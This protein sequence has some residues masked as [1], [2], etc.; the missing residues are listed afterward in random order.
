LSFPLWALIISIVIFKFWFWGRFII[1]FEAQFINWKVRSKR[2]AGA[3][4]NCGT[5]GG[6]RANLASILDT[7]S[8]DDRFCQTLLHAIIEASSQVV[9]V[10]RRGR[11]MLPPQDLC[12]PRK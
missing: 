8:L 6:G 10:E 7:S 11:G 3:A 1:S 5:Q 9:Q 4:E 2:E 12:Q